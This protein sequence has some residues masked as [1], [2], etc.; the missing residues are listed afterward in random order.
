MKATILF[1]NKYFQLMPD[2]VRNDEGFFITLFVKAEDDT[3]FDL[4]GVTEVL[5]KFKEVNS[6]SNKVSAACTVLDASAGKCSYTFA[7]QDLDTKGV[8]D[9]E[10]QVTIGSLVKTAQLGRFRIL[11]DLP[12]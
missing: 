4:T 11:E 12:A 5:L 8:Y 7:S 9:A 1:E 2:F 10:L 6:T 3:A